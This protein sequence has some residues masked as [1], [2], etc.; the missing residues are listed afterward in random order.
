NDAKKVPGLTVVKDADQ[1]STFNDTDTNGI[2]NWNTNT[3]S[4]YKSQ[5]D[6]INN[7]IAT[8]KQNNQEYDQAYSKWQSENAALQAQYQSQLAEYHRKLQE[9][10]QT[11]NGKPTI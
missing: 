7:A 6:A 4:D 3:Q 10:N 1:S 5:S 2:R 9:Y 8:Q 11:V